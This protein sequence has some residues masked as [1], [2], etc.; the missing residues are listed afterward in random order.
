VSKYGVYTTPGNV[1]NEL[2]K[3]DWVHSDPDPENKMSVEDSS[4]LVKWENETANKYC[5]AY[6]IY[7][8]SI[9]GISDKYASDCPLNGKFNLRGDIVYDNGK[10]I[11]TSVKNWELSKYSYVLPVSNYY[12]ACEYAGNIYSIDNGALSNITKYDVA[13]YNL[14]Y[15]EKNKLNNIVETLNNIINKSS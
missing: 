13:N 7:Y 6:G 12:M 11:L 10:Q 1:E 2:Q 14:E 9:Y 4:F 5:D 8:L 15:V 3:K